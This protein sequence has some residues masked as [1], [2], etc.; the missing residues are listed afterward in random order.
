MT[1]TPQT[2]ADLRA[3]IAHTEMQIKALKA[4]GIKEARQ[5]VATAGLTKADVFPRSKTSKTSVQDE[6]ISIAS[7][8][9]IQSKS[10]DGG[11]LSEDDGVT[12]DTVL[13]AVSE[14]K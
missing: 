7:I 4:A 6:G 10:A 13:A 11:E 9:H 12:W 3:V 1:T 14:V 8:E 2:I 5:I